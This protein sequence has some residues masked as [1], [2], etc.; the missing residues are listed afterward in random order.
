MRSICAGALSLVAACA[1]AG[2]TGGA[3]QDAS[4]RRDSSFGGGIDSPQNSIDAPQSGGGP[5][6]A[7][8]ITLSETG[9]DTVASGQAIS[10]NN[11]TTT[12]DNIWY[13]AFQLSDY[14]AITGGL[15]VTGVTFGIE[16]CSAAGTITVKIGSY[17]G[18]LDGTTINS[19]QISSLASA[20]TSPADT[21]GTT[22]TV[23]ITA[24]IPAGGK[25]VVQVSAPNDANGYF[26]LGTTSSAEMH[27][28]YWS[29][30]ACSQSMPETT[31]AAGQT[32]HNII[33]VAGTH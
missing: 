6:A 4:P 5:D 10:C 7:M 22:V 9:D 24:D 20:T 2:K 3:P 25:F 13:R 17:S 33:D 21:T 29:S 8:A 18:A 15:H 19:A 23:P 1:V 11:G 30:S 26:V 16:E 28:G 14:P 12:G 27:K 31:D 32:T